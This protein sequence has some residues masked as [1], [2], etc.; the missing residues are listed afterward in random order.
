MVADAEPAL[1]ASDHQVAYHLAGDAGTCSRPGD[2]LAI[3]SIDGAIRSK[4]GGRR[5][6]DDG[7]ALQLLT[8]MILSIT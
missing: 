3:A 1:D 6:W 7:F 2:D 8:N 4:H 5:R